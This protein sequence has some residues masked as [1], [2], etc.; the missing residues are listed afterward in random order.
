MKKIRRKF[1]FLLVVLIVLCIM[2]SGCSKPEEN[3]EPIEEKKEEIVKTPVYSPLTGLDLE[4]EENLNKRALAVI[5]E[6]QKSARPQSGLDKA[7]VVYEVS[8]EGGITRFLA[9]YFDN[10]D[11]EVIGPVRSARRYFLNIEKEYD[12]IFVC[13]GG[14]P[15]AFS[16][17]DKYK[18]EA[19][20]GISNDD[21]IWRDKSRKAPHNAYTNIETI[22]ECAKKYDLT[23]KYSGR[24]FLH[25]EE[26][27]IP[28]SE[29]QTNNITL[30]YSVGQKYVV[31]YKYDEQNKVYKRFMLNEEH[32][33]RETN[34][35][36]TTVNII[37]QFA[38]Q[39][40]LDSEGRLDIDIVGKGSGYYF[41][42]GKYQKITW[43]KSE[44]FGKT[45][46]Y[47]IN[48]KELV[49][50]PG[51]TWIQV[52]PTSNSSLTVDGIDEEGNNNSIDLEI[53]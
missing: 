7:D 6:N 35:Q 12:G 46:Y 40:V 48:G 21:I 5:V 53:K 32:V 37:V 23:G 4:N 29:L 45:T 52:L 38:S 8:A 9:I 13:V 39:K 17:I 14:S 49:L 44:R 2:L 22:E 19:I 31:D 43:E 27:V 51:N 26:F 25:N 28:S 41:T 18:L 3:N 16:D 50:N 20:N 33:D 36:L 30:K 24:T 47:D 42:G 34:E 11:V 1:S 15:E 10:R